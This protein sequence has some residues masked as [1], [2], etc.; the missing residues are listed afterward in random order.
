MR[1][2][3][4][5]SLLFVFSCST[6]D[7]CDNPVDCLPLLTTTGEGTIGCLIKGK[8][9]KPGG[10]QL[11]GPTQ[12]AFYQYVENGFHFGLSGDNKSSN[13][14]INI[15]L[16]NIEI[17]ENK[18]YSLDVAESDSNYGESNYNST[19]FQTSEIYT[20]EILFTNFDDLNGIVSGTFWFD[21]LSEDGEVVE[22]R[23]GRFDMK[24]Y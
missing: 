8:P 7:D 10:S 24:Y 18:V 16:R 5:L 9:F 23:E 21:A 22:I 2:I 1:Y 12:Q 11:G 14:S 4:I 3:C 6:Q 20:G 17:E 15:V 13:T 19:F